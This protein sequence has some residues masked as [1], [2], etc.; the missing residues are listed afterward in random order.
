MGGGNVSE[1]EE[2]K[3]RSVGGSGGEDWGVL[4]VGLAQ[5]RLP[6]DW[7]PVAVAAPFVPGCST[8]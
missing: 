6:G 7:S 2:E 1:G 3:G 5:G 4:G 8:G